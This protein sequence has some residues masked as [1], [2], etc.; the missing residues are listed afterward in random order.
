MINS[1]K[2]FSKKDIYKMLYKE[3][4]VAHLKAVLAAKDARETENPDMEKTFAAAD[5]MN[6]AYQIMVNAFRVAYID[7]SDEVV[8][9]I[10]FE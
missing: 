7:Q 5:N 1:M 10:T 4:E 3:A 8:P 6:F 9:I 2:K